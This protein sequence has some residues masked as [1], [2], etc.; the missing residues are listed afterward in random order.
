MKKKKSVVILPTKKGKKSNKTS[1]AKKSL[2]KT[3]SNMNLY[4]SLAYN[5]KAKKESKDHTTKKV[6]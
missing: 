4:S 5:Y 1:K 3:S 6:K 2:R